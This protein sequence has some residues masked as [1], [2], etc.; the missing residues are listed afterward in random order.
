M[1]GPESNLE[2]EQS[3]MLGVG[4]ESKR[5][6]NERERKECAQTLQQIFKLGI[7]GRC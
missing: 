3:R 2:K 6:E 1:A 4:T 5:W 7:T